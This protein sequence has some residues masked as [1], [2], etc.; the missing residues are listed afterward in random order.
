MKLQGRNL[1][2]QTKGE[3]VKLL[4]SE[5]R[6]LGHTIPAKE[7]QE[8]FFGKDTQQ[9]VLK[10]QKVEGLETTGVVDE[11][12]AERIKERNRREYE[13]SLLPAMSSTA[14]EPEH[15]EILLSLYG[16]ICNSWRMLTDVR[17]KLL[18]LVPTVSAA[19][20]ISL[21]SRNKPDEGLSPLSRIAISVFGLLITVGI[22]MYDQR[23][24]KLYIDLVR[25]GHRIEEE[26][27]I[28]TG[29]FR[30]RISPTP[31]W[32]NHRNATSI[33]Y[34]VAVGGWL[35]VLAAIWQDWI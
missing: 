22:W 29:Q 18:G 7:V 9:V 14:R 26:L 13:T 1:S 3:D 6:Q 19:V 11:K 33:I 30:G 5:L 21:L 23:N 17:F 4:H 27:G 2:I 28:D 35:F 10:F 34:T 24:T 15:K 16:E 8:T 32:V 12:T 20:L 25:R 31:D